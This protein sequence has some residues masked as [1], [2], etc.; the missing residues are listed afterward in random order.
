LAP[1]RLLD[2]LL[3]PIIGPLSPIAHKD[4]V[5]NPFL[6]SSAPA[7]LRQ[8]LSCLGWFSDLWPLNQPKHEKKS[9]EAART[10]R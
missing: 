9:R 8:I 5:T 2:Y 4:T 3:H 7:A 1:A 6:D 10:Q